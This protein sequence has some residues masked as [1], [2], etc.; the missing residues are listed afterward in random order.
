MRK[1]LALLLLAACARPPEVHL[2]PPYAKEAEEGGVRIVVAGMRS[3]E[4][5]EP[6]REFL[7]GLEELLGE[8]VEVFG[9]RTYREVLE[10][11]RQGE[12][13]LGFLC[14]LAAG[15][16]VEEGF[17][18]VLLA[19]DTVVPYQSLVVVREDAPYQSLAELRGRPFAFTDPLSNTGHAWPR[20]LARDLGEDFFARAFFTYGHDRALWAVRERLAEGAAVDRVVYATLGIQGLR[21]LAMG[22]ADPPPPVVVPKDLPERERERLMRAL[23]A[24]AARPE[25]TRVLR[26]LGL[27][28][29][30]KAEDAPYRSVYRRARE[31]LP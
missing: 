2:G 23:L 31:V 21:V 22:P 10:V 19:A 6:Y 24:L 12:A 17:V 25:S 29:F 13:E 14:T 4:E 18:Q 26:A 9:R 8:K 5:A 7:G 28:G 27:R 11:L 16:G 15:L 30:R 20:L 1:L 3:P